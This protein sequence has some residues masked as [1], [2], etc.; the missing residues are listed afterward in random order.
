MDFKKAWLLWFFS[1]LS[2]LFGLFFGFFCAIPYVVIGAWGGN[3]MASM[4]GL[5]GGWPGF[6]GYRHGV[7]ILC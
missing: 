3:K 2:G 6:P 4:R 1:T 5:P 7:G